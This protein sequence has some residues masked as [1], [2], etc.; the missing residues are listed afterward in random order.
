MGLFGWLRR[1]PEAEPTKLELLNHYG[2]RHGSVVMVE[3][4]IPEAWR[5]LVELEAKDRVKLMI[6]LMR[7]VVGEQIPKTLS[8]LEKRCTDAE[9]A[10]WGAATLS[11]TRC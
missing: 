10:L 8:R 7:Q 1:K 5:A 11:S 9:L 4:P 6:G 2:R 3:G